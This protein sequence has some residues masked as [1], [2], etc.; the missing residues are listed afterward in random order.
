[1]PRGIPNRKLVKNGKKQKSAKVTKSKCA[2]KAPTAAKV[3]ALGPAAIRELRKML[4]EVARHAGAVL[5][6]MEKREP[7]K[8]KAKAK[9]K[10]KKRGSA[11]GNFNVDDIQTS[12]VAAAAG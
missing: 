1:M 10:A 7:V 5:F 8:R 3:D 9:R 12:R 11:F 2:G 6:A 4:S